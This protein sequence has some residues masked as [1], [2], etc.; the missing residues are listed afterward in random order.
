M[1]AGELDRKQLTDAYSAQLTD[2]AVEQMSRRLNHYGAP[3]KSAEILQRRDVGEQTFQLVKFTFR[4]AMRQA[5]SSASTGRQDH[6]H[7]RHD[8]GRRLTP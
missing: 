7:R 6:R 4:G 8:A 1:Q 2:H 3:P 5:F